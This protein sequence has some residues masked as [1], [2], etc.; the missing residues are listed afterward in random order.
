MTPT[1]ASHAPARSATAPTSIAAVLFFAATAAGQQVGSLVPESHPP[2][3]IELCAATGTCTA[4]ARSI[5]L[6]A[7]WRWTNVC[8]RVSRLACEADRAPRKRVLR[9]LMA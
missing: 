7:N 8:S 4:A 3:N 5:V 2:L 6:D 9:R 1:T